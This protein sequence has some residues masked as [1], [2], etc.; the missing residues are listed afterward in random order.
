MHM[1][2]AWT[3]WRFCFRYVTVQMTSHYTHAAALT[4]EDHFSLHHTNW[5]RTRIS[6]CK[7]KL[8][9]IDLVATRN[10]PALHENAS[11]A[12]LASRLPA[13]NGA[14]SRNMPW[15]HGAF[16]ARSKILISAS[17]CTADSHVALASRRCHALM[18]KLV[19]MHGWCKP[20]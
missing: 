12:T 17:R 9:K 15:F 4:L 16:H 19:M 5:S 10:P 8:N 2:M 20:S 3:A 1:R 7:G 11:S 6:S 18:M 14:S 13:A